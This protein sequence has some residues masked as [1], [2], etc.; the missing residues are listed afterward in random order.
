[1][2]GEQ[3]SLFHLSRNIRDSRITKHTDHVVLQMLALRAN[4]KEN[5]SSFQSYAQLKQETRLAVSTLKACIARLQ[6]QGYIRVFRSFDGPK[7]RRPAMTVDS[8]RRATS[9][10]DFGPIV[11]LDEI[12]KLQPTAKQSAM[13]NSLVDVVY[14]LYGCFITTG[15]ETYD[16]L[17][18][19]LGE[20]TYRRLVGTND[21]PDHYLKMDFNKLKRKPK[22]G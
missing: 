11:W 20:S 8:I 7:V 9:S 14:E 15:N 12:D 1:M 22:V 6:K 10:S 16:Q 17:E 3:K 21:N 2:P 18:A 4:M 19:A 13:L 5:V